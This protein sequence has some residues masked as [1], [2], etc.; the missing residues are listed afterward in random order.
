M[1]VIRI[2]ATSALARGAKTVAAAAEMLKRSRLTAEG[3]AR[4]THV[5]ASRCTRIGG[6]PRVLTLTEAVVPQCLPRRRLKRESWNAKDGGGDK[7]RQSL[8]RREQLRSRAFRGRAGAV[9]VRLA[10]SCPLCPRSCRKL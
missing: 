8:C 1:T 5:C 10:H 2:S 3:R 6:A 9:A 7:V 4:A